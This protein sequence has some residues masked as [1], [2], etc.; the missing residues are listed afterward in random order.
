MRALLIICV[1]AVSSAAMADGKA[2]AHYKAGLA[3]KHEGKVDEALAIWRG[4][5]TDEHGNTLAGL[6]KRRAREVRLFET[7]DYGDLSAL[8]GWNSAPRVL[9]E[10]GK[11]HGRPPDFIYTIKPTDFVR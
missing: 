4:G 7:G 2:D 1:L 10:D 5:N 11:L 9:G 8:K 3:F 6:S